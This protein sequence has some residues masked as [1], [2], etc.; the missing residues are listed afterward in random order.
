MVLNILKGQ[1]PLKEVNTIYQKWFSEDN[2]VKDLVDVDLFE[3]GDD[4]DGIDGGDQ[5]GEEKG[6]QQSGRILTKNTCHFKFGFLIILFTSITI[7]IF[8]RIIAVYQGRQSWWKYQDIYFWV[9][10]EHFWSEELFFE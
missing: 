4:G 8:T 3:D 2:D 6:V 1:Y 5:G 7:S 10:F 9:L